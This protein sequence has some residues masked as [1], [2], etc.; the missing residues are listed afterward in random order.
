[1]K[2]LFW[3]GLVLLILGVASLLIPI[4]RNQRDGVKVGGIAIGIETSHDEKAPPAVSA[5]MILAGAGLMIAG[6]SRTG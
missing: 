4:P 6:R 3:L 1:M 2:P 5:A